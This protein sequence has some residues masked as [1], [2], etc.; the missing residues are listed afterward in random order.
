MR[1]PALCAL[2][3][4]LAT[5]SA[6]GCQKRDSLDDLVERASR[7]EGV[8]HSR[9]SRLRDEFRQVE[10][11][12]GLPS[13]LQRPALP[14]GKNAAAG[15]E[16]LITPHEAARVDTQCAGFLAA[17][18]LDASSPEFG[19]E[20]AQLA[21]DH[22]EIIAGVVKLTDRSGCDFGFDLSKGRFGDF[23]ILVQARMATRVMLVDSVARQT[24]SLDEGIDRLERGWRW[25][26]WLVE[27]R[28]LEAWLSGAELRLEALAVA[29]RLANDPRATPRELGRLRRMME[30]SFATWPSTEATLKRERAIDLHTYEAIRLGLVE[31]LFT[32]QERGELRVAGVL[33]EICNL[34][35][36]RIDAD[37]ADYL[38]YMRKV[39]ELSRQPYFAMKQ[40]LAE[41]DRLLAAHSGKG[42]Y[43][44][45]ANRLCTENLSAAIAELA[46][47]RARVE[48]WVVALSEASGEEQTKVKLN[49]ATG[50]PY[51][52]EQVEGY[53]VVKLEDS[54]LENPLVRIPTR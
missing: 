17:L 13:E 50:S 14:R 5:C 32:T 12:G 8:R 18:A 49:P 38:A 4:A 21:K 26:D 47:D 44:W 27:S 11:A 7:L 39:I 15:L 53:I 54:R 46:R 31:L 6:A 20:G 51:P 25:I 40:A 37:Q 23:R 33:E 1:R 9:H 2:L 29:E 10:L 36:E 42:D 28:Y 22:Q 41:E 24:G 35:A 43:A 48:A 30:G 52:T 16:S 45:F 3:I 34:P 19:A